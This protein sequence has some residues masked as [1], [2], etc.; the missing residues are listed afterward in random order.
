M[1]ASLVAATTRL[2]CGPTSEW[3]CER[4]SSRQRVYFANHASHLDFLVLWSSL[5]AE[6]RPRTRPVAGRDYWERS[7]ARRFMARAVFNAIL[8][9]R[10]PGGLAD[11]AAGAAA[12]VEAIER[13]MGAQ[14]SVI[15]FPEGTRSVDGSIGPFKSGLFY[16]A[17]RRPDLELIP[18]HLHNLNRILPRGETLPVPML[19]RVVFGAALPGPSGESRQAFLERARSAVLSLGED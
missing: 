1:I 6:Q 12:S 8:I 14:F 5:P 15:V 13:Q 3:R 7:P 4:D 2:V 17:Q 10:Q 11:R 18:V 16:L 19:S 9:D